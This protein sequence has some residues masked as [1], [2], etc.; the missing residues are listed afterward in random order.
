MATRNVSGPDGWTLRKAPQPA[1]ARRGVA[2]LEPDIPPAF[3]QADGVRVDET[4][5]AAPSSTARRRAAPP[6][7]ALD[8]DLKPGEE[9]LIAIR[10]ASGALTFHPS[11]ERTTRAAT[12]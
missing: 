8:V 2:R 3:L 6:D 10:H 4:F 7:L 9:A 5:E 1:G 11:A 12:G